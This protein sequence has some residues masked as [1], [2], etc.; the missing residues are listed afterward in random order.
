MV[1]LDTIFRVCGTPTPATWPGLTSAPQYKTM[2]PKKTYP[3]VLKET[4]RSYVLRCIVLSSM[5][6]NVSHS[7]CL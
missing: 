6:E 4:Y 3:R 1:Q 7:L 2:M 5:I